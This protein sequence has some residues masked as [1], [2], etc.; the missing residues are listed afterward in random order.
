MSAEEGLEQPGPLLTLTGRELEVLEAAH[1]Q[2]LA[3]PVEADG[4]PGPAWVEAVRSLTARGLID[5]TGRLAGTAAGLLV[6]TLLDVRLGAEALVVA[7]RLLG[8]PEERRDLRLLHLVELGAVVEDLHAEGYHGLDLV[9]EPVAVVEDLVAMLVPPDAAEGPAAEGAPA[10]SRAAEGTPAERPAAGRPAGEVLVLDPDT[11]EV[12][13]ER[14][15]HPSVLV[16]LTLVRSPAGLVVGGSPAAREDASATGED[17]AHLLALGPGGCWVAD[18][19]PGGGPLTFRAVTP[20][21]VRETL[22][23]WVGAVLRP[24]EEAQ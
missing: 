12:L 13:G 14:L 17:P 8:D 5:R 10:E 15:G 2:S 11:P 19:R 21:W 6:R 20:G 16:E 9:L 7:E 24:G 3:A 23:G 1:A 22:T 18:R 4:D